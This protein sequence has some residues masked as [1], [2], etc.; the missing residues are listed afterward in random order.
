MKNML[1]LSL[2]AVAI[3]A[4]TACGGGGSSDAADTYVG[5]WKSNCFAYTG[6][7]GSTY[8]QTSILTFAKA[9]A[10][11][12]AGTYSNSQAFYNSACTSSAGSKNDYSAIKINLGA[13]A[14]YQGAS[15]D[16]MVYTIVSTGEARPG[17]IVADA[18]K[19]NLV[20]AG[21]TGALPSGGWGVASPYTK[22]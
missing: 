9:S 3:A 17:Y 14:T 5:N 2:A 12:L 16:A 4:L 20:I 6:N 18:T 10:T 22:Q 7:D 13:K 1:K 11:E 8:Y 19:M 21:S 15:V